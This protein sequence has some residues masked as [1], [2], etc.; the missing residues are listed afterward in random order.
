M[1]RV[2]DL[3]STN[4]LL[5]FLFKTQRRLQEAEVQV[6]SEKKSQDYA[7]ISTQAQRLLNMENTRD[8]LER[9]VTN[10]ELMDL[11]LETSETVTANITQTI[12]DFREAVFQYEQHGLT[13]EQRVLDVQSA[14]FRAL[15]SLQ[16]DLNIDIDGRFLYGGARVTD[17][18]VDL[19]L[20]TLTAFQTAYDGDS[21]VYPVSRAAHVETDVTL[22]QTTTGNLT[23]TGTDTIQAATAGSLASL[24]VGSTI[25]ISGSV[26]GNDGTY[27]VVSNNGSDTITIDGNLTVGATTIAVTNTVANGTETGATITASSYYNGDNVNVTHRVDK[28]RDFTIDLNASDAAFEK[29]IRAMGIIAQGVFGTNGGLDQHPERIEQALF[30]LNSSLEITQSTTPP[31]FG[32]ELSSNMTGVERDIGFQ[33]VLIDQTNERHNSLISFFEGRIASTE[34]ID[35]LDAITRLLDDQQA[36]EASFQVLSRVKQLSLGNF[37]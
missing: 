1:S 30:L 3:A 12:R 33:R 19:N 15:T 11:R 31:P 36:L 22:P 5:S 18:P 35:P 23:I 4:E 2:A 29:A 20:T 6:A 24:S 9:F 37:L 17:L 25:T 32:T 26:L 7:G 13:D 8:Q 27:T 28:D 16:T 21:V 14:A 34:N 10:N